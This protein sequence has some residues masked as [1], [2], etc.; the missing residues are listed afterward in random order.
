MV[1]PAQITQRKRH[2]KPHLTRIGRNLVY[3]LL[4]T[5][6][7]QIQ[8]TYLGNRPSDHDRILGLVFVGEQQAVYKISSN[9]KVRFCLSGDLAWNYPPVASDQVVN[10]SN[11]GP[12]HW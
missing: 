9:S 1:I 11:F 7:H 3:S 10:F 5:P 4:L 6:K 12:L 2:S 8:S